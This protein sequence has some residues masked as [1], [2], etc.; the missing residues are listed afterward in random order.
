MRSRGARSRSKG[1]SRSAVK[2]ARSS[3]VDIAKIL[4]DTGTDVVVS[5]LPVGSEMATKW[6][7]EQILDVAVEALG[8][9]ASAFEQFAAVVGRDRIAER[10]Q[11]IDAA[12]HSGQRCAQVV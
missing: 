10:K 3:T 12:A 11:A 5:Y 7:V 1:V 4:R 6:Y 9:I 8:F 2:K